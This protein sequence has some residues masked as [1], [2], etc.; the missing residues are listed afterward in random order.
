M[1]IRKDPRSPY[2]QYDFQRNKVRFHGS[3]GCTS[4][5]DAE[6]YEAELKRKVARGEVNRKVA[7]MDQAAETFWKDKAHRDKNASDT[8]YQLA[9]IVSIIGER[10]LI[11][12]V[13]TSD[14]Y[15]FIAKRRG[16]GVGPASINRELGLARRLW[17]HMRA[18]GHDVPAHGSENDIVWRDLMLDEPK[19]R[20]RELS[21]DDE[22]RLFE[23]LG[24]DLAAVVRFAMLSGQRRSAVIGLKWS[25]VDLA[26]MTARVHT[27]G[28]VWH[29]FPLTLNLVELIL[30]RP[31]VDKCPFVFTYK[32]RRPSPARK[33]RPRRVKGERYPYSEEGWY[34][35]WKKALLDAK[36]DDFRFHDLRHTAATRLVR[37]TGNLKVAQ[38]L[39]GHTQISTTARYAHAAEEDV[40]DAMAAT[41]SRN[42][43]G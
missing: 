8:E 3:T 19:E 13:R 27:K 43:Y 36:I 10:R 32:C 30:D 39:L 24:D 4:K 12:D 29:R 25:D 38:R 11:G 1:S 7:S 20:V 6:R 35:E 17:K 21:K 42:N 14:F 28:N 9:N 34:R 22:K 23:A 33:D 31:I 40:R 26:Q 2:W 37:T 15:G 18:T 5:R 16:Q 41:E